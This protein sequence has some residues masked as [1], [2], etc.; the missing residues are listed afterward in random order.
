MR[1]QRSHRSRR[2]VVGRRLVAES[3]DGAAEKEEVDF[4]GKR[5][6]RQNIVHLGQPTMHA[7][8]PCSA[9]RTGD[10][11]HAQLPTGV[12]GFLEK[13]PLGP[14]IARCCMAHGCPWLLQA[15][16]SASLPART[17]PVGTKRV[18][19]KASIPAVGSSAE[20]QASWGLASAQ[21]TEEVRGESATG[22]FPKS[23]LGLGLVGTPV[24]G[25]G[26]ARSQ[27]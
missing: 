4:L 25:G 8:T 20:K 12:P 3:M 21:I 6:D 22:R 14:W 1:C 23:H 15:C 26:Y 5:D 13:S 27:A 16:K 19:W 9:L 18:V 2:G 10:R 24:K 11:W 17:V 7:P